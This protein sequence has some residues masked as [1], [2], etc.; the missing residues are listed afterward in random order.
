[1][2]KSPAYIQQLLDIYTLP[3][4]ELKECVVQELFADGLIDR[5]DFP[6][7]TGKGQKWLELMEATP[8]PVQR[9]VD[10]RKDTMA[11]DM[12]G[13]ATAYIPEL[14]CTICGVLMVV[15]DKDYYAHGQYKECPNAG[16]KFKV[17]TVELEELL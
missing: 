1:M 13:K 14:R 8:F 9:W 15:W 2:A 4:P 6:S 10:P 17:D 7:V 16:K 3:K 5:C 11:E 12:T